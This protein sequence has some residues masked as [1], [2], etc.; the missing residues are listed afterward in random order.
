MKLSHST[1]I[2]LGLNDCA[3]CYLGHDCSKLN[4]ITLGAS[5]GG[6]LP[7]AK[8]VMKYP[9]FD[10]VEMGVHTTFTEGSYTIR[11]VQFINFMNLT[12]PKPR[13]CIDNFAIQSNK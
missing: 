3:G 5:L 10:E 6:L 7:V 12:E 4:G 8:G 11:K 1:F 13:N 9:P 2:G